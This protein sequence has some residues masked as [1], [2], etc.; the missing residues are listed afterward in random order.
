MEKKTKLSSAFTSWL[1]P[2]TDVKD[3]WFG[4]AS[5]DNTV[6]AYLMEIV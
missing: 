6:Q 3:I 2:N 4:R 5:A 1:E